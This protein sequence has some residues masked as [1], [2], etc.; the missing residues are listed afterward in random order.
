M[1]S[2]TDADYRPSNAVVESFASHPGKGRNLLGL[3]DRRHCCLP[4]TAK[5]FIEF[6]DGV[7]DKGHA[8]GFEPRIVRHLS[9]IM[10]NLRVDVGK[11]GARHVSRIVPREW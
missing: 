5:V 10:E 8:Y 2:F 9:M 6:L 1:K 3:A 7:V 4:H 11:L